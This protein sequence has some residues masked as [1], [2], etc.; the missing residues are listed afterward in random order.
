MNSVDLLLLE[1]QRIDKLKQCELDQESIKAFTGK[2]KVV[3][4]EEK[5]ALGKE[6][7]DLV[8]SKGYKDETDY[9]KVI[10]LIYKG[11]D[12]EYKNDTKGDFPLLRCARKNYLKTFIVLVKSGANINQ[13]NNYL[14]T[15]TMASARHG[16]KEILE[17]LILMKADINAK[18]KDG[19]NALI[20]ARKHTQVD[21][22]N[23]LINAG[24]NLSVIGQNGNSIYTFTPNSKFESPL[25]ETNLKKETVKPILFCNICAVL[26][27]ARDELLKISPSASTVTESKQADNSN[28]NLNL[29][30]IKVKHK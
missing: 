9:E 25:L 23:M 4:E 5:I 22:F 20:S 28:N 18:C 29:E 14:T 21:C 16:N 17:I 10:E 15:A 8:T 19:D 6:L 3:S 7:F 12:T 27:E 24:A 2:I 30:I 13:K 26:D 11:A 1:Q